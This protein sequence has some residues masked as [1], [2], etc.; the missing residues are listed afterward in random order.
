MKLD[1]DEVRRL[2]PDL[3]LL[4]ARAPGRFRGEYEPIDPRA[5]HIPGARSRPW[6]SNLDERQRFL[7]PAELRHRFQ[8]LGVET[9]AEAVA[10]C[11]SGVS[12]CHN[13]LA[14]EVAGLVGGR[15]YP[16]SWSDWST[17]DDAPVAV[18]PERQE[19]S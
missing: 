10:Y 3:V 1:Y 17:R 13:L 4:D 19:R 6:E 12:A 2:A 7:G 8:D 15:L 16:G 9:G 14:L 11:G 5:G 18:G